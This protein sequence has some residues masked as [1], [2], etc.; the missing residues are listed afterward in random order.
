MS[1]A[2]YE[3][4]QTNPLQVQVIELA[5]SPMGMIRR[6]WLWML[7]ALVG[8]SAASVWIWTQVEPT[9][10]AT[11]TVLVSS[12]QIPE[13]FIRSTVRGLDSLSNVN[14]LIGEVLSQKN[15]SNLL[16]R[17]NLYPDL[18]EKV[19]RND[20]VW[21]LRANI[22]I[23]QQRNVNTRQPSESTAIFVISYEGDSPEAAAAVANDLASILIAANLEKRSAQARRT[24]EFLRGELNRAA[25]QVA[26][27]SR[28]ITEFNQAHRGELPG[29]LSPLLQKL[30][31]LQA[32]RQNVNEQM[33]S[34]E[35]R[36]MQFE[37]AGTTTSSAEEQLLQ[38]R[39]QLDNEMAIHTDEHPNVIALQRRIER[40]Q[41]TVQA[42]PQQDDQGFSPHSFQIAS[43]RRELEN[44]RKRLTIIGS[45][46]TEI[47]TRVDRIPRRTEELS[48]LQQKTAVLQETHLEFMRKVKDAE[49]AETLESAQQGPQVTLLDRAWP[50]SGPVQSPLL[51][52]LP[53]LLAAFVL[54]LLIGLALEILDPVVLSAA[55]FE[56][57]GT[58]PVVGSVY[59]LH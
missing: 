13:S 44:L 49:L 42:R 36:L 58:A 55:H 28:E 20:L 22:S 53:G 47:D 41:G 25:A 34:A 19:P 4:E 35:D 33:S 31:R 40:M 7:L 27:A 51:I 38:M 46:I 52:L 5:K 1:Q 32:E 6:R 24:T 15:L 11:S 8:V 10:R 57:V 12:Q 21:Y 45:Q 37:T 14:A 3:E 59:E 50:P 23:D 39:L 26:E 56:A 18:A 48:I 43:T 16:E 54:S 30:E 2:G 9:Y 17:H 29:D